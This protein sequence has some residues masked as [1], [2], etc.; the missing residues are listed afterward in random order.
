VT[1]EIHSY[2][3]PYNIG[4]AA[5]RQ[6]EDRPGLLDVPVYIEEKIDG[7]QFSFKR[8]DGV[9][10]F[11]SRKMMVY[12]ESPGMFKVG[13]EFV[14]LSCE[15]DLHEG[16]TYRGEYLSKPKHNCLAYD[17]VPK[18]S[19]IIYDIETTPGTFL[20]PSERKAEA[21][22]LGFEVV[23][24]LFE[25]MVEGLDQLDELLQSPS[26]LG[27]PIEGLVIKPV[28]HS[29]WGIDKKVLMAKYVR[30][31]FKEKHDKQWK[32]SNPGRKD[33]I[34]LLVETYKTPQRWN[35][36][37]QHLREQGQLEDSPRDIGKLFKEVPKDILEECGEEIKEALF[38]H[39]WKDISRGITA[40]LAEFYKDKLAKEAF[41]NPKGIVVNETINE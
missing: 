7:S 16:W 12:P 13:V 31:D 37:V 21:E 22:R 25:G 24:Q 27:G 10:Y 1:K 26:V 29:L 8:E 3:S 17:R 11:R 33:V 6:Y 23:P 28:H 14:R 30:E 38:K 18:K 15:D 4:H 35:K 19:I 5:L 40:G 9:V 36:A 41:E 32:K 34:A 20:E 39:F 2:S